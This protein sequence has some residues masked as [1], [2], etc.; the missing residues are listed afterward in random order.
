MSR[1]Q[2]QIRL[3]AMFAAAVMSGCGGAPADKNVMSCKVTEG[4]HA[5]CLEYVHP[6]LE[7]LRVAILAQCRDGGGVIVDACPTENLLGTCERTTDPRNPTTLSEKVR[8]KTYFQPGGLNPPNAERLH[9][10]CDTGAGIWSPPPAS[11]GAT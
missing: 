4:S 2:H 10:Q 6:R 5:M 11:S 8:M 1:R 7:E 3:S 9:K